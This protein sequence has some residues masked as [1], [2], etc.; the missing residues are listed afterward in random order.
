[1]INRIVACSVLALIAGC[2]TNG[3]II[4][5]P[6]EPTLSQD[7][8]K[9]RIHRDVAE[10]EV[11]D[12]VTF[13]MNEEPIYQFGD[14]SDFTFVTD[15][16]GYLFGYRQGDKNCSTDV[17]IDAGG[18]YVFSLKRGCIIEMEKE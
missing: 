10:G 9:I 14:T 11:F 1:M 17:Q 16:G 2:A 18:S 6:P 12:D 8:A 4:N 13:T 5:P 15:P 7:S 3:T